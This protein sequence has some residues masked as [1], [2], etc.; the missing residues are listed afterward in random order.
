[1]SQS[2]RLSASIASLGVIAACAVASIAPP[3]WAS[4]DAGATHQSSASTQTGSAVAGRPGAYTSRVFGTFG[5]AGTVRG[6]YVPLRSFVRNR[7]AVI[8]GDLTAT[9]RRGDGT[10]VG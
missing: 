6:H 8:Q 4:R 10:L 5:R 2:R 7:H 1:M 9:L 3:S